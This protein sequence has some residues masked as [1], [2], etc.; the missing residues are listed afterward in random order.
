[1]QDA[2]NLISAYYSE[3][4]L[5]EAYE[6]LSLD[7]EYEEHVEYSKKAEQHNNTAHRLVKHILMRFKED[8]KQAPDDIKEVLYG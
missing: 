8:I 2:I 1:M 7:V 3:K 6:K 5:A 4:S